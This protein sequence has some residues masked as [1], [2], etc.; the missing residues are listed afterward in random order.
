MTMTAQVE[1]KGLHAVR[2]QGWDAKCTA[3][4]SDAIREQLQERGLAL[5]YLNAQST[6]CFLALH[7]DTP[8]VFVG[9]MP[10]TLLGNEVYIWMIPFPGLHARHAREMRLIFE[11]YAVH[12][13]KITSQIFHTERASRRWL[14]FFGF[15]EVYRVNGLVA[16]ERKS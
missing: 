16:Y 4:L 13:T 15:K 14:E 3:L 2:V 1:V 11:T 8:L 7:D 12:Y 10:F 5:D 9:L 6:E